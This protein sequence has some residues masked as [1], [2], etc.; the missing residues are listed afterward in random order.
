M[1]A[2]WA[3][4]SLRSATKIEDKSFAQSHKY[5]T[6]TDAKAKQDFNMIKFLLQSLKADRDKE[7]FYY[8]NDGF[9]TLVEAYKEKILELGGRIALGKTVTA[10]TLEHNKVKQCAID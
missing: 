9:G 3:F 10:L 4:S 1:H 6:E 8:F 7:H 5:L 2:D